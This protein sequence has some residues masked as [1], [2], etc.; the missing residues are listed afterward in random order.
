VKIAGGGA[1]DQ[2]VAPRNDGWTASGRQIRSN[3]GACS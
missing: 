3:K 1:Q 2:Y